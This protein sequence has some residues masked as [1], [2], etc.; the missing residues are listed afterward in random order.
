MSSSSSNVSTGL[1][2]NLSTGDVQSGHIQFRNRIINGDMRIAQRG[3]TTNVAGK[4]Y[5]ID[6]FSTWTSITTG[7]LTTTQDTLISTDIPYKYGF[8]YSNK[9][10]VT[11][12]VTSYTWVAPVQVIEGINISDLM[13]GTAFG[14]PVT[15]S[16]WF[17]SNANGMHSIVIRNNPVGVITYHT[18]FTISST[19]WQYLTFIISPPP[20]GTTWNN[21]N[22]SGLEI[23]IC[24]LYNPTKPI[25]WSTNSTSL[26]VTGSVNWPATLNNYIEFTGVQL[27]KGTQA[28]SFEFRPYPIELQLCQRYFQIINFS[29]AALAD[30]ASS[31][32]SSGYNYVV[33]I[34]TNP[35]PN[36]TAINFSQP[37][38]FDILGVSSWVTLTNTYFVVR[39]TNSASRS[40]MGLMGISGNVSAEL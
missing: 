34:R 5:L 39:S 11:T 33:P 2:I 31:I 28:T 37:T 1:S 13:W 3:T 10:T 25:G 18:T 7:Q 27:E 8:R 9:I 32:L 35:T 19:N 36:I 30:N 14:Y 24:P 22:T 20:N 17:R 40:G 4:T 6:R 15:V 21:D 29:L 12:A 26:G 38:I 23:F 16:L